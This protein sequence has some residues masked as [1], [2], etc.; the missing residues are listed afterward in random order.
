MVGK[1]ATGIAGSIA[2]EGG[3]SGETFKRLSVSSF[4][5][6][7]RKTLEKNFEKTF[8]K[9]LE[10]C[11]IPNWHMAV[12]EAGWPDRYGRGGVWIELKSL[13]TLG[14]DNGTSH[15][16]K[17][18]LN[19]LDRAGDR[20]FYCAKFEDSFILKPWRE[21]R[22]QNLKTVE[23]YHYRRRDDIEHAIRH[24]ILGSAAASGA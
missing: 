19:E 11:G 1:S 9:A 14:T 6:T 20:V 7:K 24:E 5:K 22:G 8:Y 3:A 13:D 21:I 17:I 12:R 15:E 4:K 10:A 23:R 2:S 18:K 16:Q